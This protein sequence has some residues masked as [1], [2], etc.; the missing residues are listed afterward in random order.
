MEEKKPSVIGED[1]LSK[2]HGHGPIKPGPCPSRGCPPPRE[3]VS[4]QT[5]KVYQE[6]KQV[7]PIERVK[8]YGLDIPSGA[9]EV[10]CVRVCPGV[11]SCRDVSD[12]LS[13]PPQSPLGKT[14]EGEA[15]GIIKK[16]KP[17]ALE[18]EP[19]DG[20]VTL[21]EIKDFPVQVTVEFFDRN[22]MSL[23]CHTGWAKISVP[24]R[25]VL[26]SRAGEP[27]LRSDVDIFLSC[28]M[29]TIEEPEKILSS[30]ERHGC[31]KFVACCINKI[32][33]FKLVADVQILVPSYGFSPDPPECEEKAAGECPEADEEWPP[34]PTDEEG[35]GGCKSCK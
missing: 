5:K 25:T 8:L 30:D 28:L 23:G 16:K 3:I 17:G 20:T 14:V 21:G 34:Y 12:C 6:C 19:C 32:I 22:G 1:I 15:K 26:L 31:F 2:G 13:M 27:L 29:C 33:V 4:I 18:C 35:G 24:E 9:C 10:E 7:E 11:I